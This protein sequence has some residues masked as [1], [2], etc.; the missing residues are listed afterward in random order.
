MQRRN[1]VD[2][3]AFVAALLTFKPDHSTVAVLD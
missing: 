3:I 1:H 2:L